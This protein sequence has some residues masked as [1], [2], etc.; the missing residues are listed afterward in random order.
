MPYVRRQHHPR[1]PQELDRGAG[2]V[3]GADPGDRCRRPQET[4]RTRLSLDD[5]GYK[6]LSAGFRSA[7]ENRDIRAGA[8]RSDDGAVPALGSES[9]VAD[10]RV[11]GGMTARDRP[12]I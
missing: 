7:A 10:V 12:R 9:V 4:W 5:P 3:S 8:V 1:E 2:R 11:P 6:V